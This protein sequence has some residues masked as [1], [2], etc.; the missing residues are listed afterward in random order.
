[1]PA[2]KKEKNLLY[3]KRSKMDF[4]ITTKKFEYRNNKQKILY[5]LSKIN[6]RPHFRCL[7]LV[8]RS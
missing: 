8:R 5:I 7:F 6:V 3:F 1:M 4:V 2:A